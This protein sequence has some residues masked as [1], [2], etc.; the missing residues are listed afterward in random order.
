MAGGMFNTVFVATEHDSVYAFDSDTGAVLWHVSLLGSGETLSDTRGCSQVIA[1]N[2]HHLDA[3]HRS[4]APARTARYTSS[5][6]PRTVSSNYHQRLHALDVATGAELLNG[7]VEIS[8]LLS[9]HRNGATL[10]RRRAD[11]KSAR[12]CCCS[13]ARSTPAG[14][15]IATSRRTAAGSSPMP[16]STLARNGVLNIAAEQLARTRH[17]DGGRRS[18][19]RRGGQHLPAD[20]EWSIRDHAGRQGL[21]QRSGL[22][23]LV[24]QDLHCR[25]RA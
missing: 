21:S 20:G 18:R 24:P 12:R 6:C 25:R 5:P 2:R 13:T 23:Q 14:R 16:Q 9:R 11:M 10:V 4:H 7:P 3:G 17:L 1:R 19:R 22:R 15:L 8:R